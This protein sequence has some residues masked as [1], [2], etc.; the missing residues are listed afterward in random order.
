[1]FLCFTHHA[2]RSRADLLQD[3]VVV[4]HTVLGLDLHGLRDVL[5]VDVEDK[6]V[7]VSDLTLLAADLLASFRIN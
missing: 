2:K 5:G 6:L 1:M 3:V 4:V 7:V